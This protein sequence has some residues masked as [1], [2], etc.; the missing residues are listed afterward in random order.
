VLR[1]V[2]KSS[3]F[4]MKSNLNRKGHPRSSQPRNRKYARTDVVTSRSIASQKSEL[5]AQVEPRVATDRQHRDWNILFL[6]AAILIP[7]ALA[8]QDW[9]FDRPGDIDSFKYVGLFLNYGKHLAEADADYKISRLP[10]VF[11]GVLVYKLLTPRLAHYSLQLSFTFAATLFLYLS[12][13]TLLNP[14]IALITSLIYSTDHWLQGPS[15]WASGGWNYHNNACLVYYFAAL[16]FLLRGVLGQSR[17]ALFVAGLSMAACVFTTVFMAPFV[18]VLAAGSWFCLPQPFARR[19]SEFRYALAG[20]LVMALL[21]CVASFLTGGR[22]LFFLP[23]WRYTFAVSKQNIYFIPVREY[24]STA[25]WL[26]YPALTCGLI[27]ISAVCYPLWSGILEPERKRIVVWLQLQFMLVAAYCVFLSTISHQSVL[28]FPQMVVPLAAPMMP[29][30]AAALFIAERHRK[31]PDGLLLG[32]LIAVI[33]LGVPWL[34]TQT[35]KAW[36]EVSLAHTVGPLARDPMMISLF[37]ASI[38]IVYLLVFAHRRFAVLGTAI[39]FAA[40][41]SLSFPYQTPLARD[42][43]CCVN[44]DAFEG[45]I[46]ANRFLTQTDPS[47]EANRIIYSFNEHL[48]DGAAHDIFLSQVFNS[49]GASRFC[50]MIYDW[51]TL[52]SWESRQF[53]SLKQIAILSSLK[54]EEP[55]IQEF[56]DRANKNGIRFDLAAHKQFTRGSIIFAISILAQGQP[57]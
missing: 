1:S 19:F 24:V 35:D 44:R 45:V 18:L 30:I 10:W 48:T 7:M 34:V 31:L 55:F 38:C 11:P 53:R 42:S 2:P 3:A 16:L 54:N 40:V 6:I 52:P 39:C 50:P 25:Y 23:E 4:A 36:F 13:K 51:A 47:P 57:H 27:G 41:N 28:Q 9:L 22:V 46:D 15:M 26:V 56:I 21:L 14:R 12:V 49:V 37:F 17:K 33:M 20:G 29:A 5:S 8:S 32:A 43:A